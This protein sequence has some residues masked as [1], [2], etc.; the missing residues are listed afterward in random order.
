MITGHFIGQEKMDPK[1][2]RCDDVNWTVLSQDTIQRLASMMMMTTTTQMHFNCR[3]NREQLR[4]SHDNR[5]NVWAQQT[6][7]DILQNNYSYWKIGKFLSSHF[8][9]SDYINCCQSNMHR[10]TISHPRTDQPNNSIPTL[11]KS[12]QNSHQGN[13]IHVSEKILPFIVAMKSLHLGK[14]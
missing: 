5:S 10:K 14:S 4:N 2:T 12:T 7:T 13:V 3:Q 1:E 8:S 11:T 6:Y 9:V